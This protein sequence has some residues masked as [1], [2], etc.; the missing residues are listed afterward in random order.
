MTPAT[1]AP[2]MFGS[3]IRR[4]EDPRLIT[5][6]ALYTEDITLPGMVHAAMLRSPHAHAR[7]RSHR[8]QP[9]RGPRRVSWPSTPAPTPKACCKPMPCAWLLPNANLK[10]A[11]YPALAKDVVRYVG[12]AV[13]VVVAES[14]QQAYDALDLIDVELRAA[15]GGRRLA[16]GGAPG[17]A[18]AARRSP[19]QSGASTGRLPA[20]TSRPRSRRR[21]SS[22]R[23]G[24]IQQRLIPTAME[25]R[26]AVAQYLPA[27]GELT[28][29][30]TTQNPHI[31]AVP[32]FDGHRRAGRTAARHRAG[33]RRRVRQ[34]DCA[35]PGRLHHRVLL[36]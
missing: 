20:A 16:A 35:D 18:A 10:V 3:G 2:R 8:H 23:I 6:A 21:K 4:R 15:A 24:F 19:G 26:G 32:H 30:N 31:A 1:A 9:R 7:I 28:L 5:G 22:S 29:W 13:A 33:S 12:D 14:P 34:Q 17:R 27:T 36:R 11:P 25:P